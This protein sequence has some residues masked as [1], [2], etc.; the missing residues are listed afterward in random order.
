MHGGIRA[1]E[2]ARGHATGLSST[3][4]GISPREACLETL[5]A[6]GHVRAR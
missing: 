1:P 2:A 4:L 5:P 6:H 3:M